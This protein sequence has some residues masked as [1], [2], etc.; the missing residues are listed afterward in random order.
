MREKNLTPIFQ[1]RG[2]PIYQKKYFLK[3]RFT[4]LEIQ[5]SF[6]NFFPKFQKHALEDSLG[7]ISV[8]VKFWISP[9]LAIFF[10]FSKLCSIRLDYWFHVNV[11]CQT[12]YACF[13]RHVVLCSKLCIFLVLCS[14]SHENVRGGG[15]T[16]YVCLPPMFTA[17]CFRCIVIWLYFC[18]KTRNCYA[19]SILV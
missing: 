15:V 12:G 8:E 17:L 6:F 7:K 2:I 5:T 19:S 9:F 4:L 11:A 13:V 16:C 1:F 14:A 18:V 10:I 3:N